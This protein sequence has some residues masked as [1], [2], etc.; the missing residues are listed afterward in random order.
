MDMECKKG[1]KKKRKKKKGER[2]KGNKTKLHVFPPPSSPFRKKLHFYILV[3][4]RRDR[5]SL[6][7]LVRRQYKR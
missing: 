2:E 6:F 3:S 1:E 7:F 4:F 5:L